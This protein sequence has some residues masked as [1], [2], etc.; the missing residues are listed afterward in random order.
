MYWMS[1]SGGTESVRDRR[2]VS[3]DVDID[4]GKWKKTPCL[5][6]VRKKEDYKGSYEDR[7]NRLASK[8]FRLLEDA[9]RQNVTSLDV[10]WLVSA[11][12]S[13]PCEDITPHCGLSSC[14][15]YYSQCSDSYYY[16][17]KL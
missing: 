6:K 2:R 17:T 14:D 15:K 10:F 13:K 1:L 9:S 16:R 4:D 11:E 7:M 3:I 12:R 8:A 5:K